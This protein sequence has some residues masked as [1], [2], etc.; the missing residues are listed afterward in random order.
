MS[1]T[2]AP[3]SVGPLAILVQCDVVLLP[4]VILRDTMRC[5]V[6]LTSVPQQHLQ[7]LMLC[8]AYVNYAMDPPQMSFSFSLLS[9]P[10]LWF[11]W[12]L[13]CCLLSACRL[14]CTCHFHQ[15][16][17]NHCVLHPCNLSKYTYGRH[18]CLLMLVPWPMP[19]VH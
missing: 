12:C 8:L 15:W 13:L 6:D 1:L 7:T 16:G 14:H 18:M 17:L 19:E 3:T 11:G 5:V 4:P 10:L 9:L 2:I